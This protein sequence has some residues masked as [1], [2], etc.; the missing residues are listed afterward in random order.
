[1]DKTPLVMD[2]IVAGKEFIQH[3]HGYR[4][5]LAA[6]WMRPSEDGV[7][8][9]YVALNGLTVANKDAAYRE[10]LRS[11]NALPDHYIDPFRVRL[12]SPDDPAA[13]AVL[14]VYRSYPGKT[15]TR[16]DGLYL[17]GPSVTEVYL[18]PPLVVKP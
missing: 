18:Y 16:V 15:P 13:R 6:W 8:Y 11:A 2:E 7:R 14:D 5:V 1:M 9:L 10:V 12:V 3:L 4:P 17:G